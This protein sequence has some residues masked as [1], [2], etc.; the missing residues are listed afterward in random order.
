MPL[1]SYLATHPD[2]AAIFDAGMP[3]LHGNET[4]P[5]LDAYDFSTID[6]LMDV[7]GG[8]GTLLVETLQRHPSMHGVLFDLDHV[9]DRARAHLAQSGIADRCAV[10]AVDSIEQARTLSSE[11]MAAWPGDTAVREVSALLDAPASDDD[12]PV[13]RRRRDDAV[14]EVLYGS[15]VRV[16]EL[17]ALDVDSLDLSAKAVTVWGK[18]GKERRVPLSGPAVEALQAWL[19][20]RG[21]VVPTEADAALFGNERGKRLSP[22]DVR[23][24]RRVRHQRHHRHHRTEHTGCDHRVSPVRRS[25]HRPDRSGHVGHRRARREDRNAGNRGDRQPD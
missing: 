3:A 9:V 18:G 1:F 21:E 22:R 14:L 8:G 5:M 6:T 23:R 15:G 19:G 10:V 13:W 12:E 4:G 16:G 20:V 17:C 7:G 25:R 2:D 24:S 11:L